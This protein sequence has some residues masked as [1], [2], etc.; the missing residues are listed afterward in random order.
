VERPDGSIPITEFLDVS[1]VTI[2]LGDEV[3]T[4]GPNASEIFVKSFPP[5]L[6]FG[7]ARQTEHVDLLNE[8]LK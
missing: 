4:A 1:N 6:G 8:V 3:W 5:G 2:T 7:A